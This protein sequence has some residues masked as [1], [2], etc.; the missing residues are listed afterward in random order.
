[1]RFFQKKNKSLIGGWNKEILR[2]IAD[3]LYS[4]KSAVLNKQQVVLPGDDPSF[5]KLNL[6]YC[7]R[8]FASLLQTWLAITFRVC[9]CKNQ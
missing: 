7:L 8:T 4:F 3:I 6:S 5:Y 2:R 9:P 1:V